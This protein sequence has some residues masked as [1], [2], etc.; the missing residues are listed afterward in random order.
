MWIRSTARVRW[1][2]EFADRVATLAATLET[3]ASVVLGRAVAH[4]VGHL[5]MGTQAHSASG[6]MRA[7]CSNETI[8]ANR[9]DDWG[10]SAQEASDMR[11]AADARRPVVK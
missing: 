9:V 10:F 1:A 7:T 8:L 11:A 6:L 5:L 3:D 4:E 2:T